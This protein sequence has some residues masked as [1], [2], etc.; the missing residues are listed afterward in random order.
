MK[1]HLEVIFDARKH[2]YTTCHSQKIKNGGN[3]CFAAELSMKQRGMDVSMEKEVDSK[4][5]LGLARTRS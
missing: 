1:K 3:C 4:R 2:Y 5:T